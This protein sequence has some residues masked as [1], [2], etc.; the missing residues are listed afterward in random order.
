MYASTPSIPPATAS[1]DSPTTKRG[2]GESSPGSDDFKLLARDALAFN[3]L[4][5]TGERWDEFRTLSQRARA[6][7]R[8]S[9]ARVPDMT[10]P[11]PKPA[12]PRRGM[13]ADPVPVLEQLTCP[14][15]ALFGDHDTV[16]PAVENA[17]K[18]EAALRRSGHPRHEVI[19]IP[20]ADYLFHAPDLVTR[21]GK[22]PLVRRLLPNYLETMV[23]WINQLT[24][25]G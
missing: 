9:Y 23:S 21:P 18:M 6:E 20:R 25:V 10:E 1:P 5:R 8:H 12:K 7:G 16:V 4:I 11:P 3:E 22:S 19:V 17:P 15:L 24:A 14:V 13:D 2:A